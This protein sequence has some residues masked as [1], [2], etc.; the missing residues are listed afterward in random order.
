MSDNIPD[1]F[2]LFVA[3]KLHSWVKFKIPAKNEIQKIR[4]NDWLYLFLQ[5]F[6]KFLIWN[7]Q[8]P[9]TEA[10]WICWNCPEVELFFI[11]NSMQTSFMN[12]FSLE[13]TNFVSYSVLVICAATVSSSMLRW[14]SRLFEERSPMRV[15][16]IMMWSLWQLNLILQRNPAYSS[17]GQFLPF[18][19]LTRLVPSTSKDLMF[20]LTL[21]ICKLLISR[22]HELRIPNSQC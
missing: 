17:F 10:I 13:I 15:R 20:S 18:I 5:R 3:R 11:P 4:E 22:F 12:V 6:N 9:E 14:V 21:S 2:F 19:S 7:T 8:W 1:F 16:C